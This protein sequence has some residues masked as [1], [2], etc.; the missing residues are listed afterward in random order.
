MIERDAYYFYIVRQH[1]HKFFMQAHIKVG[2]KEKLCKN[3]TRD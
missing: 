2:I 1:P 3:R